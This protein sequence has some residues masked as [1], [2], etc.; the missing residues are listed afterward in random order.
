MKT[1]IGSLLVAA[2]GADVT[3]VTFDGGKG[4]THRWQEKN[5]PVMGGKSTGTFT[6]SNNLGIFDGE[7]VDVPRLK[8]PGFIKSDTIDALTAPFS[9]ISGCSAI[10]IEAKA[11]A[12]YGGFRLTIGNAH[13]PGGKYFAYGYK[14]HFYPSVGQFG[15]TSIPLANFTDFWDDATGDPIKTCQD[16]K[17]YC[18]DANTLKNLK[19]MGL[20]AEGAAGKVHLEVKKISA[21]GCKKQT[22]KLGLGAGRQ[23]PPI[24]NH[25]SEC[26]L[27]VLDPEF[28]PVCVQR[29][30]LAELQRRRCMPGEKAPY[31][32]DADG[33]F[34]CSCC[35]APLFH[36]STQF[37]QQPASSWPW[38]SFHSPPINGSDGLPSVCHRGEGYGIQERGAV[39]D[40]GLGATG[41]VGCAGCGA[42]LGDYFDSDDTGHD[43]YC[44][45][46]VC[47]IGPGQKDGTVCQPTQ[48]GDV[49][50]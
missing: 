20:W 48:P 2:A 1:A 9:D 11:D 5:D 38:P 34:R 28:E 30:E 45:D 50:V 41:E 49:V 22:G 47:L 8:A 3:L 43:H 33:V 18:P 44:I 25:A 32:K 17:I 36:P 39:T 14:A 6:V 7:V 46:G 40:L 4:T 21:S 26:P 19:T 37:D 23:C 15:V 35:G 12:K 16:D 42:H 10:D 13:A 31:Y 27:K 24:P 29:T